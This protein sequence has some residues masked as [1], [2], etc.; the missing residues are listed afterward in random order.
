MDQKL[1][2][3]SRI[4]KQLLE[5]RRQRV[6]LGSIFLKNAVLLEE[7]LEELLEAYSPAW[8]LRA[9]GRGWKGR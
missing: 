8:A 6:P 4:Y 7:L 1:P 5:S 3:F 9:Q 2:G